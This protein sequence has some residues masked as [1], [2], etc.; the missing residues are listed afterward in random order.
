MESNEREALTLYQ[1][2]RKQVRKIKEGQR[3]MGTYQLS[4]TEV[5]FKT[6][7]QSQRGDDTHVLLSTEGGTSQYSEQSQRAM[8]THVLVSAHKA[9]GQDQANKTQ[10]KASEQKALTNC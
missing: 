1:A 2:K 8:A 5:N 3:A 10:N 4:S 7:K 6:I 9:T